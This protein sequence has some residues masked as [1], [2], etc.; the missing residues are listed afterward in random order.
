MNWSR[1]EEIVCCAWACVRRARKR[2]N[3]RKDVHGGEFVRCPTDWV[4]GGKN[5]YSF[6]TVRRFSTGN[7]AQ[8]HA[9]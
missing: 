1:C 4:A 6:T 3:R 8:A 9:F 7:Q 2:I 5:Y